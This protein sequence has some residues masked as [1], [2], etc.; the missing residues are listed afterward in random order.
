[1][2]ERQSSGHT[3]RQMGR[4]ISEKNPR[5]D[6]QGNKSTGR[7]RGVPR[8]LPWRK[9]WV[10]ICQGAL[11]VKGRERASREAQGMKEL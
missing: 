4:R 6:T 1:M 5:W 9:G 7:E 10:G 2:R 8:T 3:L 11:L